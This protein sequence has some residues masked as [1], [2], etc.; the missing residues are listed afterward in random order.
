MVIDIIGSL[1]RNYAANRDE[2]RVRAAEKLDQVVSKEGRLEEPQQQHFL[3]KSGIVYKL[4]A[5]YNNEICTFNFKCVLFHNIFQIC[6]VVLSENYQ[7][8]FC[9]GKKCHFA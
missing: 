6:S 3:R 4:T 2:T 9:S 1:A 8:L 5:T 7:R